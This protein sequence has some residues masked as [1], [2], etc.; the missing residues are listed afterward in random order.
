MTRTVDIQQ[1]S[2]AGMCRDDLLAIVE[3]L[4]VFGAVQPTDDREPYTY[5]LY[6]RAMSTAEAV[7]WLR[8]RVHGIDADR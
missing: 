5:T 6:G 1:D 3:D 7:A 8:E 4:E 2:S